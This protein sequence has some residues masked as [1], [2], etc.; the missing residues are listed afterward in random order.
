MYPLLS[1][2]IQVDKSNATGSQNITEVSAAADWTTNILRQACKFILFVVFL[3]VP[4]EK[5][6]KTSVLWI[7]LT[8]HRPMRT[9]FYVSSEF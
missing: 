9:Y 2:F 8:P 6:M 4:W 3:F 5:K 7:K 1:G